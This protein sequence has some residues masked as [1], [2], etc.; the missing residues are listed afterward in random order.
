MGLRRLLLALSMALALGAAAA[1][2]FA[3]GV[4]KIECIDNNCGNMV[5]RDVCSHYQPGSGAVAIMCDETSDWQGTPCN[6]PIPC[7]NGA[8]C[9]RYGPFSASD[10]L[11]CYCGDGWQND[12]IVTCR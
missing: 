4:V 7:G 3:D 1:P 5:L 10:D 8:S 11:K 2:A 6:A 9:V 12:I